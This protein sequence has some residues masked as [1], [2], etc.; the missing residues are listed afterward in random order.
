MTLN[1]ET[2]SGHP[3]ISVTVL[4]DFLGAVKTTLLNKTQQPGEVV[5]GDDRGG[6]EQGQHRHDGYSC[7]LC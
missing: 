6:Y 4:S 1:Q 2:S 7:G 3:S 5:G